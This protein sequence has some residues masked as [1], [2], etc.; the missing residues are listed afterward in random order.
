MALMSG[1]AGSES[2][3]N[4]RRR[5]PEG[6][7]SI[8]LNAIS[9]IEDELLEYL[10]QENRTDELDIRLHQRVKFE[11]RQDM[12]YGSQLIIFVGR[13]GRSSTNDDP[14][15]YCSFGFLYASFTLTKWSG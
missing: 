15:I 12:A 8:A 5:W 7:R 4:W 13:G 2:E 6:L 3:A 10:H 14:F 11:V 1:L 9:L